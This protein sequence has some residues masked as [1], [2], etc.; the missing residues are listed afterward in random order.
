MRLAIAC[1]L[2]FHMGFGQ[3]EPSLWKGIVPGPFSVG[4]KEIYRVDSTRQFGERLVRPMQ[5][6]VWYPASVG[7]TER[8]VTV[9][10]YFGMDARELG[11]LEVSDSLKEIQMRF[12]TRYGASR[13]ELDKLLDTNSLARFGASP[14]YEK[15][16]VIVFVQG[17]GRPA[18]STFLMS[19][20]L[21]SN[22]YVVVTMPHIGSN[23]Q[24][25]ERGPKRYQTQLSDLEY[26]I[27]ETEK[28]PFV[29]TSRL[30]LMSFS[31]AA[32]TLFLYQSKSLNA[33]A[34]VT[35]D[36]V[37]DI[38]LLKQFPEFKSERISI[39]IL[40]IRSNHGKKMTLVEAESDRDLQL[41]FNASERI[42]LRMMELNHPELLSIGMM[43]AVVPKLTRFSPIGDI[44][45]SHILM[46]K[47]T[48]QFLQKVLEN[49]TL[50]SFQLDT[51]SR[52]LGVINYY[53]DR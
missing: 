2:A 22:G 28:M 31:T 36:G 10:D 48:L 30:I 26:L 37:P 40:F 12:L 41:L 39:P 45:G 27:K 16:P 11:F 32:E 1:L 29:D 15:F 5:I 7:S 9:G 42:S 13:M 43:L 49:E 44:E 17:G 35:L 8:K 53:P 4:F 38:E 21:A 19:E 33:N 51:L 20:F 46:N 47:C 50:E 14:I 52:S 6:G 3:N 24:R 34:L 18:R 25:P 23:A